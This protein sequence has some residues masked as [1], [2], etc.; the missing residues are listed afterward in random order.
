MLDID[1]FYLF[2]TAGLLLNVT[3]GPDLLYVTARSAA[4]GTKAGIVS[5]FSISTGLLVHTLA[6]A[7]GL[8]ALL[9]CSAA[10]FTAVKLIGAGYLIFLGVKTLLDSG[11]APALGGMEEDSLA[12]IYRQGVLINVLNPKVALFFLAFLPQFAS[13]ESGMFVWQIIFLGLVFITT[14]TIVMIITA[15]AAGAAGEK[16]KGKKSGRIGSYITGS[17]FIFMGLGLAFSKR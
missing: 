13:A 12:R 15:L 6:A 8:S 17:V 1:N 16:L 14:G 10:A 2:L 9:A 5:V 3:P 4:Q 11:R 7:L